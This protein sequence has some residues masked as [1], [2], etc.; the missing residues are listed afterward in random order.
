VPRS[1]DEVI[2]RNGTWDQLNAFIEGDDALRENRGR[3]VPRN[4]GRAPW[5]NAVDLKVALNVPTARGVKLE[6]TADILNVLNLL[7]SDWGVFDLATFNDLN[8]IRFQTD[9]ATGK[10]VYD[11]VTINGATFRKFDRDDLRSRWQGQLGL[12][13]RF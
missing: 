1:A 7:N 10:Y 11:L 9:T 8:P 12:R 5:T 4:A 6:F 13:V 3:I 2:V